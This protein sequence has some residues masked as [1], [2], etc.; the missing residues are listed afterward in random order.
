MWT[1]CYIIGAWVLLITSSHACLVSLYMKWSVFSKA[2]QLEQ[3]CPVSTCR[4][5]T[6][7]PWLPRQGSLE[8]FFPYAWAD[9]FVIFSKGRMRTAAWIHLNGNRDDSEPRPSACRC[10]THTLLR[11]PFYNAVQWFLHLHINKMCL[12]FFLV[13][14]LKATRSCLKLQNLWHEL[15]LP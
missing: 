8:L 6:L 2:P 10:T 15:S 13:R 3:Q 9:L 11:L 1:G 12:F 14:K 4:Q 7:A 5:S